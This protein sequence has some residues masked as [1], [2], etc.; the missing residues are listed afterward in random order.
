MFKLKK[1]HFVEQNKTLK[2]LSKE[3]KTRK[4]IKTSLTEE[5]E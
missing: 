3:S 4:N 2:K 1:Y 5:K